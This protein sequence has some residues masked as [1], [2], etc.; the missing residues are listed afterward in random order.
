MPIG[1]TRIGTPDHLKQLLDK[2]REFHDEIQSMLRGTGASV[3]G[4]FFADRGGPAYVLYEGDDA[5]V[6]AAAAKLDS[7]ENLTLRKHD[8]F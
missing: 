4:V 5:A 2:P 7:D 6:N 8:E 1:W 3:R